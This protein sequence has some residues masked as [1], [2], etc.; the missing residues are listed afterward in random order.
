MAVLEVWGP[1]SHDVAV[2]GGTR[3][4]IGKRG[5]ADLSITTD[6][7]V[8]GMHVLL[9]RAGAVWCVR[10]LGSR[11]GTFVNGER[12]FGERVLRDGDEITVGRTRLLFR[13]EASGNA[14]TTE[15]LGAAPALTP[16]ERVVLVELCRPLLS[17]NVFTQPAS[18]HEIAQVLVV[19]EA[20]VKQHLARLYE[21]FDVVDDVAGP[22]RV[23]LANAALQRGAVSMSD[24]RGGG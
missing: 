13:G 3:Y 20:A 9:E 6:A 5:D 23:Q 2:L 16:R 24:L 22:R 11:N 8:S 10:D 12:L 7:A 14:S 18:V 1:G 15:A 21:K 19:S 4:T 17:G